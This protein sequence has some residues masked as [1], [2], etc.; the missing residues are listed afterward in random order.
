[1]DA[2]LVCACMLG[3]MLGT[4]AQSKRIQKDLAQDK[5]KYESADNPVDRAK[6]FVKLGHEEYVAARHALDGGN[7]DEALQFLKDYAEQASDTHQALLKTGLDPEQ[8]SNGFR[9]LQ[10]SVRERERD[11]RDLMERVTFDQRGP[12]EKIEKA[13]DGLNQR[14]MQE[15]FPNRPPNKQNA[16]KNP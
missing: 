8:H 3:F 5:A 14:L 16:H 1:M 11:L 13:M 15:L 4:S 7:T 9:Q 2:A 12:F 6:A 10:I